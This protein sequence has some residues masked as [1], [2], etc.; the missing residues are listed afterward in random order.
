MTVT[1]IQRVY[2]HTPQLSEQRQYKDVIDERSQKKSTEIVVYV[3]YTPQGQLEQS[4]PRTIDL[5][6]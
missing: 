3:L 4:K 5:E 6:A 1:S 2:T